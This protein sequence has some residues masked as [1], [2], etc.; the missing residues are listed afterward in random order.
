MIKDSV[1]LSLGDWRLEVLPQFGMNAV[2]LNHK[3]ED[4]LRTPNNLQELE[5]YPYVFGTPLLLPANRTKGGK[6]SFQGEG[7]TLPLNEPQRGNHLHGLMFNA[8]FE[9]V[10]KTDASLK[11]QYINQGE[12]YPFPFKIT[13]T[14]TLSEMGYSRELELQ[15]LG[16][17]DMPYTMA[18]HTTFLEP[19]IFSAPIKERYEVDE[20]Y[21]PTG[22]MLSLTDTEQ[23]FIKGTSSGGK[24]LSGSYSLSGSTATVGDYLYK[25]SENFDTLVL[26]N[27]GG[28]EGFL[29][30]E[31]Q[32]GAVNGL[33]NQKHPVLQAGERAVYTHEI[34]LNK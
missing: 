34:H 21:I 15:N 25:F 29:C 6:F 26:F 14:D 33:N 10:S 31:P 18:Y 32:A 2:K 30:I 12:R 17:K 28:K 24:T 22:N 16:D 11:A 23:E 9:V 19:P 7:Y 27:A 4:V 13:I 20:N 3:G 1:C 5:N 8:P